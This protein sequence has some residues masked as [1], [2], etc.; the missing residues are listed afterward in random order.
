MWLFSRI[1]VT[2]QSR[3]TRRLYFPKAFTNCICCMFLRETSAVPF[4]LASLLLNVPCAANQES[5]QP[6]SY[7]LLTHNPLTASGYTPVLLTMQVALRSNIVRHTRHEFQKAHENS[8]RCRA[9]DWQ[10]RVVKCA[11]VAFEHHFSGMYRWNGSFDFEEEVRGA[12]VFSQGS[13]ALSAGASGIQYY[14]TKTALSGMR[15]V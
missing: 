5:I 2:T 13:W 15:D 11:P 7:P 14:R 3:L 1:K 12:T 6:L 8:A 9:F 10:L 4:S